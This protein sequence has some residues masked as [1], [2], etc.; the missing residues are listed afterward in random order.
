MS[1]VLALPTPSSLALLVLLLLPFVVAVSLRL[2]LK[3]RPKASLQEAAEA[4]AT[5]LR[6]RRRSDPLSK[7]TVADAPPEGPVPRTK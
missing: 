7:P 5:A 6:P 3:A 4:L 2:L 1:T